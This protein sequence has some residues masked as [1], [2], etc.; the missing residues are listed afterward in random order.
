MAKGLEFPVVFLVGMEEMIFPHTRSVLSGSTAE[1]EEERRLCYVG[2][3]RAM[4][5]LKIT[6]T[7]RRTLWGRTMYNKPSRF[8]EEMNIRAPEK[9]S[10]APINQQTNIIFEPTDDYDTL[11]LGDHVRHLKFGEGVV[12]FVDAD[13]EKAKVAF[14]D[15]GIKEFLLAYAKLEKL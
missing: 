8:L 13:G 15:C 9:R 1:I 14:P 2:V 5:L 3:T 7:Y 6:R 11:A 10:A 12:V 4:D